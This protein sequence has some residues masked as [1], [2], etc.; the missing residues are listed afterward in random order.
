MDRYGAFERDLEEVMPI[1]LGPIFPATLASRLPSRYTAESAGG[2]PPP[3]ARSEEEVAAI[4]VA[5]GLLV[6]EIGRGVDRSSWKRIDSR[7]S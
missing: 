6:D 7:S 2:A 4:R 3:E 1:L 5:I